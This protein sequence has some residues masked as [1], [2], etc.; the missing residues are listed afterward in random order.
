MARSG[1]ACPLCFVCRCSHRCPNRIRTDLAARHVWSQ[2]RIP[3]ASFAEVL[4][5]RSCLLWLGG[6]DRVA[7][8]YPTPPSGSAQRSCL[9]DDA[10]RD[11]GR[12]SHP[13]LLVRAWSRA[14]GSGRGHRLVPKHC[15]GC[16]AFHVALQ[17]HPGQHFHPRGFSWNDGHRVR[18][19]R[20]ARTC[21]R[22]RSPC[23]MLGTSGTRLFRSSP[24]VTKRQGSRARRPSGG[25]LSSRPGCGG[26]DGAF[27][28]PVL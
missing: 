26:I 18:I 7:W 23:H 17:Q 28:P 3:G 16:R 15:H 13:A 8:V 21:D 24:F 4:G 27:N 14:D 6:G 9:D 20:T 19:A 11:L 2:P 5:R 1:L 10:K 25:E 12:L 22:P